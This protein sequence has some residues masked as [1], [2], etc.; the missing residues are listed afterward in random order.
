MGFN[1]C[2]CVVATVDEEIDSNEE[3]DSMP[4]SLSRLTTDVGEGGGGTNGSQ[5][6]GTGDVEGGV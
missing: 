2:C 6:V 3:D 5:V 1:G 4:L